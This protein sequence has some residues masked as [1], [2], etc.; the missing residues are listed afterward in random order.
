MNPSGKL[1]PIPTPVALRVLQAK[2][3]LLPSL[4]FVGSLMVIA[5]LWRDRIGAPTMVGQADGVI[6][7]WSSHQAGAAGQTR[8]RSAKRGV[9]PAHIL[10]VG[11]QFEAL[12]LAMQSALKLAGMELA[13]PANVTISAGLPLRRGELVDLS[14]ITAAD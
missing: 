11:S 12:P 14:I 9:G 8:T 6:T 2:M 7:N 3:T 10:E 13:L 1:P 4:V 5:I